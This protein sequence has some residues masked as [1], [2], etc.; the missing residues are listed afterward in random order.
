MDAGNLPPEGIPT[1]YGEPTENMLS[2]YSY[3][4]LDSMM[5]YTVLAQMSNMVSA[6]A[7]LGT[8]MVQL[9]IQLDSLHS[10][11]ELQSYTI[12]SLEDKIGKLEKTI[13]GSAGGSK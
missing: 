5:S 2:A 10:T 1:E 11:V 13:T 7:M 8:A 3:N 6:V 12:N 9:S 4:P